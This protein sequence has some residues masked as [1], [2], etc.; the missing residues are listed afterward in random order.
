MRSD[1]LQLLLEHQDKI[2]VEADD[3]LHELLEDLGDSPDIDL[4][5]GEYPL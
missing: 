5:L 1:W 2:A 4:L 3:M